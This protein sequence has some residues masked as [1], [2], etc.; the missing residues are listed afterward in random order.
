MP[1][2]ARLAPLYLAYCLAVVVFVAGVGE[3]VARALGHEPWR[4][5][6]PGLRVEPGGRLYQ[7]DPLLGYTMLP[8][9]F[10][11]GME[12]GYAF[13]VTHGADTLRVVRPEEVA[14]P[15]GAPELWIFG[16]SF[17]Y[18]W[19]VEDADVYAW[20]VQ[21]ALPDWRVRN[22]AVNG[23]GTV[24]ALLRLEHEL[25]AGGRPAV[26][27][28][29]HA[30]FHEDRNTFVRERGKRVAPFST[31]GPLTQ[32]R[33][34]LASDGTL[35]I[36]PAPVVYRPWP[37]MQHSALVH[38]VEQRWNAWERRRARGPE[39]TAALVDRFVDAAKGAGARVVV[40]GIAGR[41][42]ALLERAAQRG[43][44]PLSMAL[45][46]DAPG[47]RNLPHDGH[48]SAKA[49]R[50]YAAR[51]VA[52]VRDRRVSLRPRRPGASRREGGSRSGRT[53]IPPR[54]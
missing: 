44:T 38:L 49:H 17:S 28:L 18:G 39:V 26:V 10:R 21:R 13:R 23:Y 29:A 20:Q 41:T 2:S 42:D 51:V 16:C 11:V 14:V 4:P 3:I 31:L 30:A 36:D 19:A 22:F 5:A 9:R 32:P 46:L 24:Q 15:E 50:G 48:P 54:G 37:G 43:A 8:G 47:M 12:S 40:A 7:A 53:A 1:P 35:V 45:D 25:A 6:A 34:R 27:L 52:A 33:A